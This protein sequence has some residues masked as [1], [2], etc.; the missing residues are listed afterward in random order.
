MRRMRRAEAEVTPMSVVRG[1]AAARPREEQARPMGLVAAEVE[2]FDTEAGA[3]TVRVLGERV[4]A[5]LDPACSPEVVRTALARRERVIV[6]WEGDGWAALGV[7]RT[8]PTP[9]VDEG[10][11]YVIRA[12]RVTID[13]E[14]EFSVRSGM[15]AI[16]VR[17]VGAIESVALDISAR[18]A[19]VHKI[20]GRM[21]RL[22]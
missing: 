1:G 16:A 7:L 3:L 17:A 8:S 13:A 14:H 2:D 19:G 5:R 21:I 9:G 11:E 22:N 10:D 18:A 4:A 6:Q 12:R 15:A 20:V